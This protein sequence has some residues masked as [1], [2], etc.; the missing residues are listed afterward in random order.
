LTPLPPIARLLAGVGGMFSRLGRLVAAVAMAA[1]PVIAAAQVIPPSERPGRER[2]RFV[3]PPAPQAQPGGPAIALPSTVAPAGA[4]EIKLTI[5]DV[6]ITG[7][8][9]YRREDLA[10][11][12]RGL[13]GREISLQAIYDLA[14][15][16]TAK[17][18]NDGYVLSRAIVPPQ[19]L[20]RNGAV[21]H[22]EV[23]EG[24]I[25]RVEWPSSL[26]RYRDFFSDYTARI[27]ADR[28][29]NIR[30]IERYLLLANDLPGLQFRTSLKPSTEVATGASTLVVEVS[31]K[32]FDAFGRFD[33]RG[34]QARGPYEYLLSTT[35]NNLVGM[36]EALTV[37]W[38]SVLPH[39]KQLEY[40]AANYRQVL[41]S[42]G[43]TFFMSASYSKGTPGTAQL[44]ILQYRTLG[45][46]GDA[47][48]SYP[49]VRT[50]ERNLWLSGLVFASDNNSTALGADLNIDRLRGA[51]LKA[52][53][54][55]ADQFQ[56]INQ[57]NVTVSEGIEGLGSTQ[58]GNP[59]ASHLNG[60]VD[61]SKIEATVNRTQPLWGAFSAYL[62]G[63]GQYA[64]TPLLSPE[65]CGYGGRFFG[66]A[67]DP[68]QILGDSCIEALG[69]L[70]Y[71]IT[72]GIGVW[73][74]VELYGFGDWGEVFNRTTTLGMPQTAQG[75]SAG[76]GMRLFWQG[77]HA[78]LQI[79]KALE[80]PRHDWRF[81]FALTGR[82]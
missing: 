65:Q 63:Y 12:Y 38:A 82:Y 13:I 4:A 3:E 68:S 46:Y 53:G 64:G 47:G 66:R 24:Y 6:R 39:P 27:I 54:D 72:N 41:T 78:D 51:R 23:I 17:Y 15:R 71:D 5:R 42:E 8:T 80:G 57:V 20:S 28:P 74:L 60:R 31:E 21:I 10:A 69:E 2:E 7:V 49:V 18:G 62:A 36:H 79:A 67:Y 75:I 26:S 40:Y 19:N 30:T 55:W 29:V 56:G 44:E 61:F 9:V 11:L 14:R 77:L 70:R 45:P 43:L 35:G 22:I 76:T 1:I 52:D 32:R 37:T 58:N 34:T 73:S 16:I 33:N 25:D 50:R 48:F 59:L 81:F